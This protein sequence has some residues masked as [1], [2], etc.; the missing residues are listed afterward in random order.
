MVE[1]ITGI[2]LEALAWSRNW[3]GD[4]IFIGSADIRKAF[5]LMGTAVVATALHRRGVAAHTVAAILRERFNSVVTMEIPTAGET[6]ETPYTLGGVMGGTEVP[7]EFRTLVESATE[8]LVEDWRRR[9]LGLNLDG[10]WL[11]LF[12]W[13]DDLYLFASSLGMLRTMYQELTDALEV[14]HLFWKAESLEYVTSEEPDTDLPEL[15][16][17]MKESMEDAK[18]PNKCTRRLEMSVLGIKIGWGGCAWTALHG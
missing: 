1:D 7:I 6:Q 10:L 12:I 15:F 4:P 17:N 8:N 5:N 11:R 13:A 3:G 2:I 18:T 9:G 16:I 14:V